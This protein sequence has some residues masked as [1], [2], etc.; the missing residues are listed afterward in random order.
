M[1]HKLPLCGLYHVPCMAFPTALEAVEL[2]FSLPFIF[3][4]TVV[5]VVAKPLPLLAD[6]ISVF[7]VVVTLEIL[8]RPLG[9]VRHQIQDPMQLVSVLQ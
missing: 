6:L 3:S 5:T 1:H 4:V 8:S 9:F 7:T 2:N